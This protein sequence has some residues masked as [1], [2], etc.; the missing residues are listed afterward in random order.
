M[1]QPTPAGEPSP[2]ARRGRRGGL[3]VALCSFLYLLVSVHLWFM[4]REGDAWWPATLLQFSPRW[5]AALPLAVLVPAALWLRRR[6]LLMLLPAAVVV[7][8][9][10]MDFCVPWDHLAGDEPH[11]M[12]VRVMTCNMHYA[13]HLD[14]LRLDDLV[15]GSHP[16]I[17]TLQEW[18]E[19]SSSAL[20]TGK[21][22]H[23]QRTPRLF[24]ASRFPIR[25]FIE[26]GVHSDSPKG[27]IGRFELETP[28]GVVALFS[29]HLIS[30][31]HGLYEVVHDKE[32]G[33]EDIQVNSDRRLEQSEFLASEAAAIKGPRLLAGDFNTPPSGVI[34]RLWEP[35][36]DAFSAAGWGWG[37]T[38]YG[39]R[40]MVRIDHIF[41]SKGWRCTRCWVGPY[42]GSLHRPVLAD[43]IWTGDNA[44]GRP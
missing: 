36:T 10:F 17:V 18:P 2:P 20:M 7:V 3:L 44:A 25:S 13:Q 21:D 6:A 23:V 11:G 42:I 33:P 43:L 29:V 41:A 9:P 31:R 15:A 34:Y 32:E 1:Q 39:G 22:W 40:T 37:Y 19:D 5:V 35:Y 28:A 4:L 27:N 12:A 24:L 16:D 38:F 26:L 14:P 30:P 8:G